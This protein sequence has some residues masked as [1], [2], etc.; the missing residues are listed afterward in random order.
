MA[1]ILITGSST[2]LGLMAGQALLGAG[3]DVIF[4]ARNAGRAQAIRDSV[5]RDVDLVVGDLDTIAGAADVADQA[6]ARPPIDAVIHNAGV[7]ADASLCLTCDGVPDL[8]A[9]NVLAPYLLTARLK[10]PSRLVYLSSDMHFVSPEQ[11]DMLW[12]RR[13][14]SGY[15]AYSESK[16]YVTA[17]ALT[18]ARLRPGVRVNA[19][20]PGWVPTRMGGGNAPDD[21]AL[22]AQTQAALAA[23]KDERLS[24]LTGQYL[25][26][27]A[28]RHP[29]PGTRDRAI[30]EHLLG[31]CRELTGVDI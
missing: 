27:M 2:G 17:L 8:F 28:V 31:V 14:W 25:Y 29:A 7:G 13:K 19:V 23:P 22:G 11:D 30:Q 10:E 3:H 26:H 4:H 16:F 5:K 6:I 12:R 9:V 1:R 24:R 20:D 15:A 21:L 18:V